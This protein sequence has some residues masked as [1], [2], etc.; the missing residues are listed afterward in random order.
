MVSERVPSCPYCAEE[1]QFIVMRV[2]EEGG[3]LSNSLNFFCECHQ[4]VAFCHSVVSQF[5]I[6]ESNQTEMEN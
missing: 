1:M 5:H 3:G 2:S 6:R 4:M